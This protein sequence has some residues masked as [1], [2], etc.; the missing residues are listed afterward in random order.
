MTGGGRVSLPS[1]MLWVRADIV[2]VDDTAGESARRRMLTRHAL[3]V[4]RR[5]ETFKVW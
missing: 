1:A 3:N 2:N 5:W 4:R